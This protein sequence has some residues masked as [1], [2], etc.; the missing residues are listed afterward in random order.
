MIVF[1]I[2]KCGAKQIAFPCSLIPSDNSLIPLHGQ[3]PSSS[4]ETDAAT[5]NRKPQGSWVLDSWYSVPPRRACQSAAQFSAELC[6][7]NHRWWCLVVVV[8]CVCVCVCVCVVC[9]CVCVCVCV[10]SLLYSLMFVAR[11]T[12]MIGEDWGK[13]KLKEP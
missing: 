4:S 9:V 2:S 1:S 8:G 11:V 13:T 10:L 12:F 3:A 5:A 7:L 6:S